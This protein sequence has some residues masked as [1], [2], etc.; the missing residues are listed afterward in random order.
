M[1]EYDH[2]PKNGGSLTPRSLLAVGLALM[3]PSHLCD[4]AVILFSFAGPLASSG[5]GIILLVIAS[6]IY[7]SENW[8]L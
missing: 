2:K 4:G 6:R 1:D 5:V 3:G 8:L 7:R